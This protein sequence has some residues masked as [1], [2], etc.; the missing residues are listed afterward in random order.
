MDSSVGDSDAGLTTRVSGAG[1]LER[2]S[3]CIAMAVELIEYTV[4]YTKRLCFSYVSGEGGLTVLPAVRLGQFTLACD[5]SALYLFCLMDALSELCHDFKHTPGFFIK[6][7][8]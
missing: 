5:K 4:W 6:S 1:M 8:F 7:L 2:E 3:E